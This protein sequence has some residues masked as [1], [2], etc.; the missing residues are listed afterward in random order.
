M[1][2]HIHY[3]S[4]NEQ[5]SWSLR[6]DQLLESEAASG[7]PA[8]VV[9]DIADEAHAVDSIPLVRGRGDAALLARRRLAREFPGVALTALLTVRRRP[10]NALTDVV[11]IAA[12][13]A[14]RHTAALHELSTRHSLRGVYTPAL[15]VAEWL[16]RAGQAARQVLV[17][18]PT[19]AGLRLVFVDQG[20]PLLSRLMP[21]V[22]G[23]AAAVEIGRTV[24]YLYNTQRVSR[25]TPVQIWFWGMEE[26]RVSTL[27]PAGDA[28]R[29]A[30]TPAAARLVNPASDGFRALLKMVAS[31]PPID[32]LAPHEMR[33]GWYALLARRWCKGLAA[34]ALV[35]GFASAFWFT[36]STMELKSSTAS[37]REEINGNAATRADIEA[38]LQQQGLTLQTVLDIPEAGAN[39]LGSQVQ[40][41]EAFDIAGRIFGTHQDISLQ[42]LEFQ[43][44]PMVGGLAVD[45]ACGAGLDE[46]KAGIEAKFKLAENLDV[47]QRAQ[48]LEAVRTALLAAKSW[49]A[50]SESVALDRTTPLI[51]RAGADSGSEDTEWTACLLHMGTGT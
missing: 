43:S 32:Q 49:H 10:R 11:L 42:S 12:D 39:L 5:V 2:C 23:E 30:D 50:T 44:Q 31:Q 6:G 4:V 45:T 14:A 22:D 36:R 16:R 13:T 15:L 29:V 37:L 38:S 35:L 26:S 34:A 24:Q 46:P 28:Y 8:V 41:R 21:L 1:A 33:I 40:V 20:R 51:A 18:L 9:L 19:P 27:L 48:S 7:M 17:V 47:R 25:D 3:L